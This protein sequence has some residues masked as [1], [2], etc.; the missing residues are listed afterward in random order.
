[1]EINAPKADS[2]WDGHA[3]KLAGLDVAEDIEEEE[4][5]EA[6]VDEVED[7]V[8]IPSNAGLIGNPV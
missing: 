5:A 3:T 2:V 7:I 1:M 8:E 4:E 6:R